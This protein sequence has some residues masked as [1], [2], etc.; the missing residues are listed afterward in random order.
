MTQKLNLGYPGD[1]NIS[2]DRRLLLSRA[3][4]QHCETVLTNE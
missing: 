1:M 2:L 3:V 4:G